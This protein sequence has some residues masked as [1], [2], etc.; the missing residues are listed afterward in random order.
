MAIGDLLGGFNQAYNQG[1]RYGAQRAQI[2]ANQLAQQEQQIKLDAQDNAELAGKLQNRGYLNF[3]ATSEGDLL[4]MDYGKLLESDKELALEL[5]NKIPAI[6]TANMGDGKTVGVKAVDYRKNDDGSY[7]F[8]MQRSDNGAR[9]P[10][11]E[12]RTQ[13]GDDIVAKF[14]PEDLTKV[15]GDTM[16]GVLERGGFASKFGLMR[17]QGALYKHEL[18][19]QAERNAAAAAQNAPGENTQDMLSNM[20]FLLRTTEDEETLERIAQDFGVDLDQA[21]QM[22]A[23]KA[24]ANTAGAGDTAT[25]VA[26]SGAPAYEDTSWLDDAMG[27]QRNPKGQ[28]LIRRR[29]QM[30]DSIND[31][32]PPAARE[33]M[34]ANIAEVEAE[35]E[36]L[37]Q[38]TAAEPMGRLSLDDRKELKRAR[39]AAE[40]AQANLD[41]ASERGARADS[42]TVRVQ[43]GKLEDANAKIAELEAK[44]RAPRGSGTDEPNA[45]VELP[46]L[47]REQLVPLIEEAARNPD[48]AAKTRAYLQTRGVTSLDQ[49]AEKVRLREIPTEEAYNAIITAATFA[50]AQPG[51]KKDAVGFF[52]DFRNRVMRNEDSRTMQNV[53]DDAQ[54]DRQMDQDDRRLDISAANAQTSRMN[55]LR[56]AKELRRNV[57]KDAEEGSDKVLDD[58]EAVIQAMYE[59]PDFDATG[60][61]DEGKAAAKFTAKARKF[62]GRTNLTGPRAAAAAKLAPD[63]ITRIVLELGRQ[64]GSSG[65]PGWW[66]DIWAD[67]APYTVGNLSSRLARNAKGEIGIRDPAG[68]AV[69]FEGVATESQIAKLLGPNAVKELKKTIPETEF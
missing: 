32:M 44:M 26:A 13:D 11:T 48:N 29:Q 14:S 19:E 6:N 21:R 47:T 39:N 24:A 55:A 53:I 18:R 1:T 17:S 50:A 58:Y 57:A 35:L 45:P 25:P 60:D 37:K 10:L 54:Q 65:L 9:V 59:V 69:V 8:V 7:S 46:D 67:D 27:T 23:D 31:K 28:Q 38:E 40:T 61:S 15:A 2:Q 22:A 42:T 12:R 64:K 52:Q 56:Q 30:I 20:T 34:E 66:R 4:N 68:G 43:T 49:L 16:V 51:A 36:T 3:D 63:V 41:A 5:V 33:K 62:F